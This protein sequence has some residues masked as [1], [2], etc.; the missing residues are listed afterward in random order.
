MN[1]PISKQIA[2][3][4]CNALDALTTLGY[5]FECHSAKNRN[6]VERAT[7]T[8][9]EMCDAMR[10]MSMALKNILRIAEAH[11]GGLVP[12]DVAMKLAHRPAT[13]PEV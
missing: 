3:E 5:D 2:V 8:A 7:R 1:P 11:G 13:T 6:R 10:T 12:L 4:A 9:D